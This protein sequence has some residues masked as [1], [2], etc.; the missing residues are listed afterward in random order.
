M[1][2]R[3]WREKILKGLHCCS[4]PGGLC[5]FCPY[6]RHGDVECTTHLASDVRDML[7]RDEH[8]AFDTSDLNPDD[9]VRIGDVLECLSE[10][11]AGDDVTFQADGLIQWAMGKRALSKDKLKKMLEVDDQ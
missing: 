8:V 7:H 6:Q 1:T 11:H 10:V 3:E 2:D 5:G 4:V 9:Y